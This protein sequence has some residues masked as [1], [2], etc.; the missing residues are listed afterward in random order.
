MR[1]I[2]KDYLFLCLIAVPVLL[3]DQISKQIVRSN[4][5]LGNVYQ[6]DLWLSQYARIIHWKNTGAA[7]GMFQNFG[8]VIGVFSFL[9]VLGIVFFYPR[10][11]R[12]D[13]PLRV[14]LGLIV[15]G[16]LGNLLDR[17]LHGYVLDFISVGSFP[18]INMADASISCGVAVFV[19]GVWLQER[20]ANSNEELGEEIENDE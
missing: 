11:P 17:V 16:A 12:E 6:P 9:V 10:I 5:R 1:K 15:G 8:D 2:L 7:L 14:G 20:R 3:V 4:V 19:I 13:W 18:V